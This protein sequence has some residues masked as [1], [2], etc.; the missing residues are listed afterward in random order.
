MFKDNPGLVD[1]Y[2]LEMSR[3]ERTILSRLV[4]TRFAQFT[5][6]ENNIREKFPPRGTPEK[7]SGKTPWGLVL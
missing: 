4:N 7:I 5:D 2:N 6:I 1:Y 3:Q